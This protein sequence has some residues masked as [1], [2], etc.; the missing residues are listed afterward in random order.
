MAEKRIPYAVLGEF[1]EPEAL[2]AGVRT[3]RSDGW[4]IEVFSPFPLAGM[5]EALDWRENKVPLAFLI[6]GLTG[7]LATFAVE[8]LGNYD[9]PLDVGGRPLVAMPAF[10]FVA[11]IMAILA[12][13]LGG[14][15]A[16]FVADRLPRLHHPLFDAE[17]FHLA[18]DDRFFLAV[19]LRGGSVD[20]KDARAA[21]WRLQARD[22][23]DVCEGE[24]T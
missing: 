4:N 1:L 7:G 3:L 9:Y 13:V 14:I 23:T 21:L 6:C 16:M 24:I 19:M 8:A 10:L 22:V 5:G 18:S 11:L 12:A 15:A 2:L 20:P 17:R